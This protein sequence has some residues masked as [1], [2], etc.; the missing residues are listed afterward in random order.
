MAYELDGFA[1]TITLPSGGPETYGFATCIAESVYGNDSVAGNAAIGVSSI[2]CTFPS[3]AL[4]NG[5]WWVQVRAGE[6]EASAKTIYSEKHR[7]RK[8][9]RVTA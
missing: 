4:S 2:V 9:L 8:T 7:V 5:D 6:N 3:D 1:L